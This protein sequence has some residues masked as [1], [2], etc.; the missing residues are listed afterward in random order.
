MDILT[1]KW[2]EEI[3]P[4]LP[5]QIGF[6]RLEYDGFT[7][8]FTCNTLYAT[9]AS[10]III[11]EVSYRVINVSY[12]E[13]I[14]VQEDLTA[15]EFDCIELDNTAFFIHG[16]VTKVGQEIA[17]EDALD[18][19]PMIFVNDPI[20]EDYNTVIDSSI[21]KTVTARI[22]FHAVIDFGAWVISDTYKRA[23]YPMHKLCELFCDAIQAHADTQEELQSKRI[24]SH[25]NVSHV[26]TQKG[27]PSNLFHDNTAGV[28][29][30]ISFNFLKKEDCKTKNCE[31]SL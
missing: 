3:V 20:D 2:F 13:F 28:E 30:L 17:H 1:H 11:N 25:A 10:N 22:F 7:R 26:G 24:I 23:V 4:T 29:L 21:L 8:I 12:N 31:C 14:D 15:L 5:N 18:L 9:I 6:D 19:Y 16:T 27:S